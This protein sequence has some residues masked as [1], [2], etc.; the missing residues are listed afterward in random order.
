MSLTDCS[1]QSNA[2]SLMLRVKLL[3]SQSRSK[4]ISSNTSSSNCVAELQLWIWSPVCLSMSFIFSRTYKGKEDKL[5]KCWEGEKYYVQLLQHKQ[6]DPHKNESTDGADTSVQETI[7]A[8]VTIYHISC[9]L[10]SDELINKESNV[11]HK[12]LWPEL[13]HMEKDG[14]SMIFWSKHSTAYD[15]TRLS[16]TTLPLPC[17]CCASASATIIIRGETYLELSKWVWL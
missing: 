17:A 7:T 6:K 9:Q 14:A 15:S 10:Y 5:N 1:T 8:H 4:T 12:M 2:T 13:K 3:L 11:F 16:L